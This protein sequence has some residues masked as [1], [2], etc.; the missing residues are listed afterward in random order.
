MSPRTIVLTLI[1][2]ACC[3]VRPARADD[4]P[5]LLRVFLKDGT[6]L[7]SYGE[8]ARVGDRVVFSMPTAATPNPP[9]HLVDI[10]ADRVDWDH[11][12][13][14]AAS[15][16][17]S[18]Y[19]RTQAEN[20]YAV[21]SNE[22]AQALNDV[23]LTTDPARRLA[24]AE[25]ARKRLSDWPAEHF[26]YRAAEIRQML[27]ML[28]EAIA[29][30]RASTG[31]PGRFD[32]SFAAFADPA[33]LTEPLLPPPT[34]KEA[35]ENV[36]GA[37]KAVD[38]AA[39]RTSLL[40]AALASIEQQ[41]DALPAAWVVPMRA[42]IQSAIQAE[43]RVDRTYR[44]FT[45]RYIALADYRAKTADVRGL[46]RLVRLVQQR[47][48]ALGAKRPE[49][50]AS[51]LAVIDQ[52]LDAARRLQLARERFALRA[53]ILTKYR[54]DMQRPIDLL[55][56]MTPSLE[57]IK[58]LAGSSPASLAALER[59][60]AQIAALASAIVPPD[61]VAAAHALLISATQLA[62]N[63]AEIRRQAAAA[64]DMTRAWDASS[65]AAGALMLSAKARADI[66]SLVR[67]PRLP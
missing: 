67:P 22:I 42:S 45:T 60:S 55:A 8:P 13:R 33:T 34:P 5:T 52:K 20:D 46:E 28:D 35:I 7:V 21:L 59:T 29:D 50:V 25:T 62:R 18:H 23:T 57:S 61:E 58:S 36:L 27:S 38:N 66:Q 14:Y 49:S 37:A 24:I 19:V 26:G 47:D 2:A 40:T 17:A 65:A 44:A 10:A 39:E 11:T 31:T 51:L 15:A 63:A 4:E 16:R 43:V 9:L 56:A 54:L 12:N 6:S 48:R 30:L 32:L 41:Q 1:V 53:P 64:D 3:A